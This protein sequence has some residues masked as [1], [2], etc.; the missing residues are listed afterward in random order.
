M[1]PALIVGGLIGLGIVILAT[2]QIFMYLS[3]SYDPYAPGSAH[4]SFSMILRVG[5]ILV[6]FIIFLVCYKKAFQKPKV[7]QPNQPSDL[8][9]SVMLARTI[10]LTEVD[11]K[12]LTKSLADAV[13]AA[14]RLQVDSSRIAR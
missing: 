9:S 1:K 8:I 10:G 3:N 11:R 13:K 7:Y 14:S 6:G 5:M 2:V 12:F 4:S